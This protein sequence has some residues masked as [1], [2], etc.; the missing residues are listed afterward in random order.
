M[1]KALKQQFWKTDNLLKLAIFFFDKKQLF[2]FKII[3]I[4]GQILMNFKQIWNNIS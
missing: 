2:K 3:L 1:K 4:R